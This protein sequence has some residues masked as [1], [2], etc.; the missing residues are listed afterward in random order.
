MGQTL[1]PAM[2]CFPRISLTLSEVAIVPTRHLDVTV[3]RTLFFYRSESFFF[4]FNPRDQGTGGKIWN[5]VQGFSSKE[6]YCRSS[7]VS[8]FGSPGKKKTLEL[9]SM[10]ISKTLELNSMV[11]SIFSLIGKARLLLVFPTDDAKM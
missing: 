1:H 10:V 6:T 2:S 11:I 7:S 5:L 8:K 4:L 9:T 3:D